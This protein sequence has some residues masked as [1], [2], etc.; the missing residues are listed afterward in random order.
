M[1]Y[2][3]KSLESFGRKGLSKEGFPPASLLWFT[4]PGQYKIAEKVDARF[5][6]KKPDLFFSYLT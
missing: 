2:T 5:R 1:P 3:S 4:T 6:L